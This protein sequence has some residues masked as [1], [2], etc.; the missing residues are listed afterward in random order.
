[1]PA[2]SA[3]AVRSPR[4]LRS[5]KKPSSAP[6][7]RAKSSATPATVREL[8]IKMKRYPPKAEVPLP[9]L[10]QRGWPR[11]IYPYNHRESQTAK[12]EQHNMRVIRVANEYIEVDI[13]PDYG[14]H[15]WG[16]KDLVTGREIF[17]RADALKHQDLAVAG[18]WLA[19]GIEFNFP[20][21]HS[22]L[23]IATINTAQGVETD[24]KAWCRI[25][26]TDKLFGLQWQMTIAL[27]TRSARHRDR[28]LAAQS[29]GP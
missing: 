23:T 29:D 14:G 18:P 27:A 6:A 17:H 3:A 11:N 28:R 25:G 2:K 13:L 21:T 9:S 15:I 4:S 1:M 24:G 5:I 19:T 10:F 7:P 8:A 16:A 26:A 20:V 22:I 12:S